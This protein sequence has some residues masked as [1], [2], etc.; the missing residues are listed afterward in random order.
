MLFAFGFEEKFLNAR[1]EIAAELV[2]SNSSSSTNLTCVS[3]FKIVPGSKEC[4][5]SGTS[6]YFQTNN[7]SATVSW[8]LAEDT[9]L[10]D[11][12]QKVSLL[13]REWQPSGHHFPVPV[14]QAPA[15]LGDPARARRHPVG[16]VKGKEP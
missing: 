5:G 10:L 2:N 15:P 13:T 8:L 9:K 3:C 7:Q 1:N 11:Q 14:L 4:E 6:P 16:C 12:R